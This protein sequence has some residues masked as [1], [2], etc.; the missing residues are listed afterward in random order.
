MKKITIVLIILFVASCNS[1]TTTDNETNAIQQLINFYSGECIK[2][3]GVE[4]ISG[5]NKTYFEIEISK[6]ELLDLK[7]EDIKSHSA[8]I[9]YLFYSN[10]GDEKGNYDEIRVKIILSNGSNETFTYSTDELNEILKIQPLL[11][12]I[13]DKITSN[14]YIE[15]ATLFD[16]TVVIDFKNIEELFND[17]KAQYGNI[18]KVQFQGLEFRETKN[19]GEVISVKE[20]IVLE[21]VSLSM[22][23]ILKRDN[24]KI[25][26]IEFD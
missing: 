19:F 10:L 4:S 12:S 1:I 3:K 25:I 15:L 22:N 23:V 9:A 24:K 26:S 6:S 18:K 21:K 7:P 20:A 14:N 8:N 11:K 13:N 5:T 2:N 17:L 16:K